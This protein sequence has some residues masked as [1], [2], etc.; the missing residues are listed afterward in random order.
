ME[1]TG[2]PVSNRFTLQFPETEWFANGRID[3][4]TEAQIHRFTDWKCTDRLKIE[5]EEEGKPNSVG[6]DVCSLMASKWRRTAL[7]SWCGSIVG[8]KSSRLVHR[9][10]S[11]KEAD[12]ALTYSL[13]MTIEALPYRNQNHRGLFLNFQPTATN[14]NHQT[15]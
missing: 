6:K 5:R 1:N 9:P 8:L 14:L 2:F 10:E 13:G 11:A 7:R 3:R 4:W 12:C 15:I